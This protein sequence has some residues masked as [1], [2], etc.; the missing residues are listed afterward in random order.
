M[1]RT[2]ALLREMFEAPE[3]A[4]YLVATG[5]AANALSLAVLCPPWGAV[6]CHE[7]AHVAED[8]CGAPEFYMPGPSW[9]WCMGAHGKIDPG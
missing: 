5:T 1:L 2:T 6:F 7:H 4:V 8:E 3:A 9:C